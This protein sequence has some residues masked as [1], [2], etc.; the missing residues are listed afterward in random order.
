MATVPA[1]SQSLD[2]LH[3]D[4]VRLQAR[5][6]RQGRL[7]RRLRQEL[8][9]S[10][11]SGAKAGRGGDRGAGTA[12]YKSAWSRWS[13]TADELA[14]NVESIL[15]EPAQNVSDLA[16]K[17]EALAWLLLSDGAVVDQHAERQVRIFGRQLRRMALH[18]PS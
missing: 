7:V 8:G 1:V 16:I 9:P 4:F 13:A 12:L 18:P 17:F 15:S 6:A 14:H 3:L 11:T 2:D 10:A 5:W